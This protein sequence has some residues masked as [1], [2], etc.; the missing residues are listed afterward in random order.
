MIVKTA[1]P[2]ISNS[3]DTVFLYY[4][5]MYYFHLLLSEQKGHRLGTWTLS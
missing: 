2:Y 5:Y 3:W 4:D 1:Q